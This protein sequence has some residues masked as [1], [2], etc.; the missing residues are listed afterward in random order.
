MI[1][2]ISTI[3]NFGVFKD[4]KC[5]TSIPD[6]REINVIYGWNY[7]GK[8]TLSRIFSSMRDGAIHEDYKDASFSIDTETG[9]IKS[10]NLTE[11][12]YFFVFNSDYIKENLKWDIDTKT[13]KGIQFDVGVSNINT[14]VQIGI[15]KHQIS[16]C[17][18][19]I[20]VLNDDK[21]KYDIYEKYLFTR[22]A[23]LISSNNPELRKV[24]K[25][26]FKKQ[27][28]LNAN[29][30]RKYI[31][32]EGTRQHALKLVRK[33]NI[34]SSIERITVNF[35]LEN[36]IEKAKNILASVP[37]QDEVIKIL[38]DKNDLR[39]W[40]E[41]GLELHEGRN[42]CVFCDNEIT[43]A[44]VSSL[45]SFFSS[46]YRNLRTNL[47]SV[48][49]DIEQDII[50]VDK[51]KVENRIKDLLS[52]HNVDQSQ[53][54]YDLTHCFDEY[55]REC[56]LLINAL[57]IKDEYIFENIALAHKYISQQA[58]IDN[59]NN[60]NSFIDK[61]NTIIENLDIE[62]NRAEEIVIK[63]LVAEYLRNEKFFGKKK[64]N[65]ET[66][67]NISKKTIEIKEF[68]EEIKSLEESLKSVYEGKARLN[69]IISGFLG[70]ES[71]RIEVT[72]DDHFLL[73]RDN[74]VAK[75]LSEGEKT[76][77]AFSYFLTELESPNEE[78]MKDKIIYI[79]DP[80]SSLD[81]NH[82]AQ[83]YHLINS[84]FFKSNLDPD[85]P[86]KICNC[87]KQLF[88]STHNFRFFSFLKESSR[89]KNKNT[90]FYL[91]AKMN[92]YESN[93]ESLPKT[94]KNFNTE[95]LFLFELIWKTDGVQDSNCFLIPNAIR[96]F[97]EIYSLMR[98]PHEK[99]L[100]TRL[101][102]LVGELKEIKT[103][104]HLSHF[105]SFEN[106]T[107]L[108][109]QINNIPAAKQELLN[110]LSNDEI[111]FNSLKKA[112]GVKNE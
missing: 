12:K 86:D 38:N 72:D 102:L 2:K 95:Y 77:I 100:E 47:S 65:L 7:S 70:S 103:I 80:I 52:L 53:I 81:S 110:I 25:T 23:S 40:V 75:N 55:I 21:A 13:S 63:S 33:G 111:H 108:D 82:I 96:R 97:L 62:L 6:F 74:K 31:L 54:E 5:N 30:S 3:K 90:E 107:K 61:H 45:K 60:L 17:Q 94:L 37:S 66:C 43:S 46:H 18:Y 104:N 32:D 68:E 44:R 11:N 88:I 91:L 15:I 83:V 14:H 49:K 105:T 34:S 106:L 67:N 22:E 10:T 42:R 1:K 89:L 101:K 99:S 50:R 24:T 28:C 92:S 71:L 79:D 64:R 27:I 41:K 29:E 57:N 35:E 112:I 48:I 87:F 4:F 26:D 84:F 56:N 9:N 36:N 98:Y 59:I 76:A 39:N 8:T 69:E 19:E 109:E 85:K 16:D 20:D 73:L 78:S 51:L 58:L 93:L